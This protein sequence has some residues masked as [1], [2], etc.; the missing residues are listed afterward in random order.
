MMENNL[1]RWNNMYYVCLN[2]NFRTID[3]H[4]NLYCSARK[5]SLFPVK[6]V[7]HCDYFIQG[8]NG[9]NPYHKEEVNFRFP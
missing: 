1:S 3:F 2:C 9:I 6:K 5:I 8:D 4:G 7:G